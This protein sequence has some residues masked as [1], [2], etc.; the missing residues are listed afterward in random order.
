MKKAILFDLDGTLLPMPNLE[1]FI[2]VYF[3]IVCN[4]LEY[5]PK[6]VL[7]GIM[8]GTNAMLKNDGS[9]L[10]ETVFWDSFKKCMGD[11][12]PE[13]EYPKILKQFEDFYLGD[14]DKVKVTT[15][16]NP[17]AAKVIEELKKYNLKLI[18]AT[19]PIFPLIAVKKRLAWNGLDANDFD[20][21]TTYE[22]MRY[23]KPN[24]E[25][26]LDVLKNN[27]LSVDEVIMVGNDVKEDIKPCQSL[28]IDTIMVTDTSIGDLDEV[29][30][31]KVAMSDLLSCIL[32]M[33]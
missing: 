12:I 19:S 5:D 8:Y 28:G 1:K 16:E 23:C 24:V 32:G 21:I 31:P 18:I 30:V 14:F 29:D 4:V 10:N 22:N 13:N 2:Q 9:K 6:K 25:F 20:Y 3:G 17:E 33:L 27:N 7:D 26:Y 15:Y 11:L